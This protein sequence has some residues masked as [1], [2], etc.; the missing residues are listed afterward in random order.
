MYSVVTQ[1]P[2]LSNNLAVCMYFII[3]KSNELILQYN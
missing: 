1:I 2:K 3:F